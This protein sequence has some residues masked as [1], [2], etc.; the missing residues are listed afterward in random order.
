[1]L[2][3][4]M[5]EGE[6]LCL[7]VD[8]ICL[9][10]RC[11]VPRAEVTKERKNQRGENGKTAQCKVWQTGQRAYPFHVKSRVKA[12]VIKPPP[13]LCGNVDK[14]WAFGRVRALMPMA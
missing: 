3:R 9:T 2:D 6:C 8:D 10:K 1:M 12:G 11:A 5:R 13:F 4:G 7:T 14:L